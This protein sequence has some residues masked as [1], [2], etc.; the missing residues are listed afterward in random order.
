ML[1]QRP[2]WCSGVEPTQTTL[3]WYP[4][5]VK[6]SPGLMVGQLS[7]ST[8]STTAS[9]NRYGKYFRSRTIPVNPNSVSQQGVRGVFGGLAQAWRTLTQS[10]RDSWSNLSPNVPRVDSLGDSYVLS[11]NA[12]FAS[13]NLLRDTVGDARIDDAPALDSPHTVTSLTLTAD[14]GGGT[15]SLAYAATGGAAG[16]NLI[17]RASAP[18]SPGRDYV[19][20]GELKQIQ[21]VAGN[22]ATPINIL[23]A[24]E[25]VFGSG[26]AS[27]VG[28]EIVV[29]M[30][31]VSANGLP[32]VGVK[33]QSEII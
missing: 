17:I 25:V 22:V 28:M 11:G 13:V 7:G 32:G 1:E 27:Q 14:G 8:G 12:L 9:H 26:W 4:V 20:R 19:S 6:Y 10:Q 30:F 15:M 33:D 21:V 3:E 29:E 16:N 31:P 24:Y 2:R 5:A 18:R 23:A